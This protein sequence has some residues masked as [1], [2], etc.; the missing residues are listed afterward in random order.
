MITDF[1]ID[2]YVTDYYY[3]LQSKYGTQ[4]EEEDY[5]QHLLEK[6]DQNYE[7]EM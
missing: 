2:E 3:N 6:D 4:K 1:N 5:I 7:D